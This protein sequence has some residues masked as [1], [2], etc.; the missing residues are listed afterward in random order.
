[1]PMFVYQL[2]E[3]KLVQTGAIQA[4][5]GDEAPANPAA[6]PISPAFATPVHDLNETYVA[7]EDDEAAA[8]EMTFTTVWLLRAFHL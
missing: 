1:M 8:R 2:R 3:L 4:D 6:K 5:C 7:I